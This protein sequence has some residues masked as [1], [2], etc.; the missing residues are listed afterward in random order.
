MAAIRALAGQ[1]GFRIVEDASHAIGAQ[2]PAA[3]RSATAAYS[4]ITVFS[5]HPVKIIT[6]GEGGMAL[7]NDAELAR[8]LRLFRSHGITRDPAR[9]TEPPEGAWYYEQQ[10]LGFNYRMTDLQAALGLSQMRADR[11]VHRG[12]HG[13]GRA[14]RRLARRSAGDPPVA[15]VRHDIG[16]APL[17]RRGRRARPI[18]RRDVRDAARRGIGV[19][20]HYIPVHLQPYYRA[21]GFAPGDF[22]AAERYYARALSL[23]M[24]PALDSDRLSEVLR[25]VRK[26]LDLP[27]G[28][29]A[30][31]ADVA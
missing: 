2:L 18:A 7:T 29:L 6:T 31:R 5:F 17:R 28:S 3:S 1:Y 4:D 24:F 30:A 23:P 26:A 8:R 25:G 16:L 11:C 20:V 27:A 21:L 19:T 14:L 13:A 22:P 12:A 9:W 10:T 15:A